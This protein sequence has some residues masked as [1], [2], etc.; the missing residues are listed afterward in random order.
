[1]TV[2]Q[3]FA[4]QVATNLIVYSLVARWYLAPRLARLPLVEALT[5]LILTQALRTMGLVF[6]LPGVVGGALPAAFAAPGA[7]GD[8]LAVVLALLSVLALRRGWRA[9]PVL[10]WLFSI[11]GL[12]DFVNAFAQGIRFDIVERYAL[13]PA[14][15]I[16]TFAAPAFV[17]LHLLAVWLLVTRGHEYERARQQGLQPQGV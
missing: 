14:W 15:F 13:G 2:I 17:V 3:I 11:E 7:Y 5:A 1:M 6:L 4:L 9:A 16:P 12:L 8:L 10:V